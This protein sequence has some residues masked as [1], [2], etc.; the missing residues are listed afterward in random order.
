MY[1]VC[2]GG[3]DGKSEYN[4]CV[5]RA[6][7]LAD[8]KMFSPFLHTCEPVSI[9]WPPGPELKDGFSLP[10]PWTSWEQRETAETMVP[11]W[12]GEPCLAFLCVVRLRLEVFGIHIPVHHS[13]WRTSFPSADP[14]N[15]WREKGT[16]GHSFCLLYL[17]RCERKK[18]RSCGE[19]N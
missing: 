5:K 4:S 17:G 2:V 19:S 7:T 13:F 14:E 11:T 9:S 6:S 1:S 12:G 3:S 15:E 18:R 10:K 16:K 8:V